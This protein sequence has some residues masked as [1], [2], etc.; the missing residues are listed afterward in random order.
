MIGRAD[1]MIKLH[2]QRIEIAEI[3]NAVSSFPEVKRVATVNRIFAGQEALC[4]FIPQIKSRMTENYV[5]ILL[6]YCLIT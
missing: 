6:N 4:V 1:R 3:E 2:G 5:V